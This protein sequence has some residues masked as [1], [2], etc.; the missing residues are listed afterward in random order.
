VSK[1]STLFNSVMDGIVIPK[2]DL[3]STYNT[4]SAVAPSN[5]TPSYKVKITNTHSQP[6][7]VD[8]SDDNSV[9]ISSAC[10]TS[11]DTDSAI[12][13]KE[14][15]LMDIEEGY[16]VHTDVQHVYGWIHTPEKGMK[17]KAQVKQLKVRLASLLTSRSE[18]YRQR[19]VDEYFEQ[20]NKDLEGEIKKVLVKGH[21]M[22]ITHA[23]LTTRA[24]YDAMLINQCVAD[25]N[26]DPVAE[27]ICCR[28]THQLKELHHAYNKH[29][30]LNIRKQLQALAQKDKKNTLVKVIGTI[31]D[32]K[33][34]ENAEVDMNVVNKDLNFITSTKHFKG[35]TK[36]RLILVFCA[37]SVQFVKVLSEQFKLKSKDSLCTFIDKKLGPKSTAGHFCK[38][39]ILYALDPTDY[40]AH[41]IKK[42]GGNFKRHQTRIADVFIQRLEVDLDRIQ[43]I[44][45][46]KKYGDGGK[47]LKQWVIAKTNKSRSGLFLVK[48]LENCPRYNVEKIQ[49]KSNN[50]FE[51]MMY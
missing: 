43:R 50:K 37:N 15:F 41:K 1:Q 47:E 4:R 12:E 36:T 48:M 30:K 34:K 11:D 35:E 19:L 27:I 16:D 2:H 17:Q 29:C 26:I 31:L 38:T 49:G 6:L 40:Y 7:I 45:K 22:E 42:L 28:S 33:R 21:A 10:D 3:P 9:D 18:A 23:L 13:K 44:W 20:Y 32:L 14:S 24:V 5:N 46:M 25:W 39:R 51:K 8:T